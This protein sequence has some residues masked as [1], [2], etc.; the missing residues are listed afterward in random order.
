MARRDRI[1]ARITERDPG[2]R[3]ERGLHKMTDSKAVEAP[4]RSARGRGPHTGRAAS[5]QTGSECCD[6]ILAH[7]T[8]HWLCCPSYPLVIIRGKRA[9]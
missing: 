9:R 2:A 1:M 3:S 4:G 6:G 8:W 5:V 7:P